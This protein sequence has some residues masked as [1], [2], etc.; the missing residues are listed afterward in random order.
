MVSSNLFN[1]SSCQIFWD[2]AWW[3]LS[4]FIFIDISSTFRPIFLPAFFR[5]STRN[6]ELGPLLNPRGSPVLIPL[7][8]TG[9]KGLVFLYCYSPAVKIGRSSKFSRGSQ[10][11]QTPEEGRITYR[12]KRCG[13]NNK[14]EHNSPKTLND[15]NQLK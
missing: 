8:I 7:A 5:E 14:D 3:F 9:Y 4:V 1:Y 2:E 13:N 6:F 10:V 12:P 11:R 15:K